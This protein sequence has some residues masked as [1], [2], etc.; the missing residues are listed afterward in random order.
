MSSLNLIHREMYMGQFSRRGECDRLH[1]Q[2]RINESNCVSPVAICAYRRSQGPNW[3]GR[4]NTV[5]IRRYHGILITDIRTAPYHR[6]NECAYCYSSGLAKKRNE[7]ILLIKSP[8]LL[9]EKIG[10]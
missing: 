4:T 8:Y 3:I 1:K 7:K 9:E 6:G 5:F 2:T 10:H